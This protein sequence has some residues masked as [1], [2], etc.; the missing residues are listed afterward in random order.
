MD[1]TAIFEDP[2]LMLFA[3][4]GGVAQ[5]APMTRESYARSIFFDRR[6]QPA[7]QQFIQV[8]LESL[9]GR[10]EEVGFSPPRLRFVHHFAHSGSTLLAR[11]LDHPGNLVIREPAH[12]RQ[13][14]VTAGA[15]VKAPLPP[16]QQALLTLSLTM[17]GKR[18]SPSSTVIVKG[19]VPISLLGETIAEM[20]PGQ[21]AILLYLPLEDY[22]A[23]VLRTPGHQGWVER[24][25]ANVTLH[26]D[27]LIGDMTGLTVAQ[28]AAALWYSMIKRFERLLA[29]YAE[30]RSLDANQLFN[31]P[32]ETITAASDLLGAGLDAQQA[33]AVAKGPLISTYSKDPN[34]PFDNG[35]RR[36]RSDEAKKRLADE[37]RSAR[38]WVDKR[39]ADHGIP[40]ALDG[41]LTG[42]FAPLL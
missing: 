41:P 17:L 10:L 15:G 22:C 42:Q 9:L 13:L 32:A 31:R 2:R 40:A 36:E 19:N 29:R 34:L 23:A 24:V 14:G 8:P 16:S 12:L 5:F 4:Q 27:P 37:L 1:L 28:R 3:L 20:D 35:V 6:L 18:F 25:T 11:A 33:E 30:M 38:A 21:P 26:R 39:A 7:E